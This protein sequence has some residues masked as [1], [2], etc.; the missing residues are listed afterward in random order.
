MF[1]PILCFVISISGQIP[2]ESHSGSITFFVRGIDNGYGIQ[3]DVEVYKDHQLFSSLKTDEGGY[4]VFR[5]IP[6]KYEFIFSASGYDRLKTSFV[7]EKGKDL[8]VWIHLTPA[9][10]KIPAIPEPLKRYAK[11]DVVLL[12]G[13]VVDR[14]SGKPITGVRIKT[15]KSKL[16]TGSDS[17][18][19]YYLLLP[20][21]DFSPELPPLSEI[22][23]FEIEGY[24]TY[25]CN[26]PLIA[27]ICLLNVSME[28]GTGIIEMDDKQGIYSDKPEGINRIDKQDDCPNCKRNN[29]QSIIAETRAVYLDPPPIIRVGTNCTG[30]NCSSV[31]VMTLEAY[32]RSGIDDEWIASWHYNSLRA[33]AVPYRSYGAWYVYHPIAQ[34][35]DITNNTYCQVWN[36]DQY[37]SCINAAIYTSGIMIEYNSAVARSEYSAENNDCGCGNGYSGTG[38]TWPCISDN[39]CSGQSCYGH[40]RGMCQWGSQRWANNQGYSWYWINNHYYNPGSY[41]LSTPMYITNAWPS[42]NNIAPTETFTIYLNTYNGAEDNHPNIMIGASL[43]NGNYYSD[44]A[45]DKKVTINIGNDSESR[46]F[47]V[48][49]GTPFGTYDL[50]VAL[51]FDVDENNQINSGDFPLYLTTLYDAITISPEAITEV[52][53]HPIPG[54]YS[55]KILPNPML[56][57]GKIEYAVVNGG[58]VSIDLFDLNGRRL[59]RLINKTQNPG[60]YEIILDASELP[61]SV[62]FIEFTTEDYREIKK[63]VKIR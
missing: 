27:G 46:I 11:E 44:P 47:V 51:W 55:L 50:L 40:G 34:N 62:Y 13:Y 43:Y 54:R 24:K 52:S 58:N 61:K 53:Q 2:E 60:N 5:N 15:E 49:A 17:E 20:T 57:S 39:V 28:K 35:Y 63:L 21:S 29:Y 36:P 14:T 32:V 18:G 41:Y 56:H 8:E 33:G 59:K 45:N 25:Q 30:Y 9:E 16:Q 3:T 38:S 31:E 48:P 4:L 23:I 42:P 12:Y 10:Y 26:K 7:I 1:V 22:I 37:Q 19:F 6:Y